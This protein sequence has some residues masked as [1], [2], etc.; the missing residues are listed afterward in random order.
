MAKLRSADELIAPAV[1]ETI[2][3]LDQ[4]DVDAAAVKLAQ[5]Y[6]AVIDR[7]ESALDDAGQ[8]FAMIDPE[9]ISAYSY[10]AKLEKKV[11]AQAVLAEIGP[12]LLA[13]LESLGAT[14]AARSKIQKGG[15]KDAPPSGLAKLRE[16]RSA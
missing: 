6:A 11:E 2:D 7:A 16:A 12:K 8:A 3:K 10:L 13:V 14:P 9:D 4:N 1:A 5:R 15:V